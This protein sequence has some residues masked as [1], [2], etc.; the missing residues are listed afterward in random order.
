MKLNFLQA[1]VPLTKSFKQTKGVLQ[2]S[3]YPSV[4][5]FTSSELTAND[6][7]QF[8]THLRKQALKGLQASPQGHVLA[9]R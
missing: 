5:N 3:S 9:E 8:V 2:K 7:A 4:I 6:L 1:D